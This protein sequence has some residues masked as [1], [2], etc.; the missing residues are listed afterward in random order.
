M[1]DFTYFTDNYDL[2]PDGCHWLNQVGLKETRW[3]LDAAWLLS[4]YDDLS[5]NKW[6]GE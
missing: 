5:Y 4:Y 1:K 6:I 3:F 2:S